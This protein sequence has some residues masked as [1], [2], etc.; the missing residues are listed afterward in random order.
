MQILILILWGIMSLFMLCSVA[1]N[2]VGLS[3]GS[4]ITVIIIMAIGGPF[5]I[6]AAIIESLLNSIL[7]KGWDNDDDDEEPKM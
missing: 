7:P 4:K 5:L 1:P 6:V 2:C 3:W